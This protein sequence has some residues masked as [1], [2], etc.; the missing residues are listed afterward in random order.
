MGRS[1]MA[2]IAG[3][4]ARTSRCEEL[5]RCLQ[6]F[7]AHGLIDEDTT[8][9]H[10]DSSPESQHGSSRLRVCLTT[11]PTRH[12]LRLCLGGSGQG[13]CWWGAA[14]RGVFSLSEPSVVISFSQDNLTPCCV[15]VRVFFLFGNEPWWPS[16]QWEEHPE[17]IWRK[18]KLH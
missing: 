14:A 3:S 2:S 5:L 9:L 4:T 18:T 7:P 13:Y 15:Q 11:S 8:C 6:W 1:W 17:S 16:A 12:R 10:G